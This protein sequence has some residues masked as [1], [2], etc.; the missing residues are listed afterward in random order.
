MRDTGNMPN[1]PWDGDRPPRPPA[2]P[3]KVT[4]LSARRRDAA[5]PNPTGQSSS[6]RPSRRGRSGRPTPPDRRT[7][8]PPAGGID[9]LPPDPRAGTPTNQAA[10][11]WTSAQSQIR[12]PNTTGRHYPAP[13]A[14]SLP[15]VSSIQDRHSH[16]APIQDRHNAEGE[17]RNLRGRQDPRNRRQRREALLPIPT[18]GSTPGRLRP[19]GRTA[20][21]PTR[22]GGTRRSSTPLADPNDRQRSG[23]SRSRSDRFQGSSSSR[24]RVRSNN[25]FLYGTRLIILGV[26]LGVIAGT[27][28]SVWDPTSR[29]SAGASQN[30]NKTASLASVTQVAAAPTAQAVS[31]PTELKLE[32]EIPA[33]KTSI[34]SLLAQYPQ[35]TPGVML[36]EP[37]TGQFVDINGNLSLPAASTIKIPVL[38]AFFQEVDAGR[39]R[40]DERLTMR[41]DLIASEAGEMQYQPVGTKFT[42]LETAT[43]MITISDNTATN[44]LIDRLGGAAALNQ[45]FQSWGLTQTAIQNPLPDVAGT[46][47]TSVRDM[48]MLMGRI[49]QGDLVSL[50]SRD[51]L[52]EIMR[53]TVTNSLL[54]SGLGEGASIAHKTGHINLMVGDVGLID[55]PNGRRYM[56]AVLVKKPATNGQAQELIQQIS[57]Q[58]YRHFNQASS[59][60]RAPGQTLPLTETGLPPGTTEP[61]PE[62]GSTSDGVPRTRIAQP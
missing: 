18:P 39:I 47:I 49:S 57:R 19:P 1:T 25:T 20:Q 38:I 40:L 59:Q 13:P 54:P 53:Q 62:G 52:L 42:A 30:V 8:T 35:L 12:S 48:A 51:R 50:R 27:L 37:E 26:G 17:T 4:S 21:N 60:T 43:K 36:L 6:D 28:L 32:Q 15:S 11:F 45:R 24:S 2:P 41:K 22:I 46:N 44:M 33:L 34:Q 16:S 31:N 7:D 3:N 10:D 29:L 14:A 56:A 23:R 61:S 9:A 5:P 58:A 55:V